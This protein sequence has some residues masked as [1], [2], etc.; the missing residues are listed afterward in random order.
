MS[1]CDIHSHFVYGMDDG[2]RTQEEMEAMLDAAWADGVAELTATPHVTPGVYE[3]NVGRFHRHLNEAR[4]YCQS[5]GYSMRLSPGAE[6]LYTPALE[7]YVV[8][9]RLPTLGNSDH[10]LL[11]FAPEI[12]YREIEAAVGLL[13]R[14][15][16]VP[17]LAHVERY[18]ALS[19]AK[20][21]QLKERSSVLYQMN[22]RT[23]LEGGG[24]MQN[25]RTRKWLQDRLIDYIATDSH[26]CGSRKTCMKR[27]HSVLAERYGLKYANRLTGMI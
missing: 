24:L 13:E 2:A 12:A 20:I 4:V 7:R 17:V 8:E 5:R 11:E 21:Y 16:Y 3:F 14:N 22:C 23:V 27:A 10:V 25:M 18:S 26:N 19:G 15:E 9:H 1:F 6:I